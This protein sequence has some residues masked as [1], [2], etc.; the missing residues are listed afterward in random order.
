MPAAAPATLIEA[1][2]SALVAF[3]RQVHTERMLDVPILNH[4]LS[5][6]AVGFALATGQTTEGGVATDAAD[7][8][9]P[10]MIDGIVLTPWFMSLY[11]LP[12]QRQPKT[13]G[14]GAKHMRCFGSECFEFIAGFDDTLGAY[15]SCAMFSPMDG[16]T[17]QM[18]AVATAEALLQ[19]LRVE[20]VNRQAAAPVPAPAVMPGRR[21]FLFGRARA[22]A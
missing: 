3:Y 4:A 21:S 2:V 11:R 1:R 12:L 7:D 19:Q 20:P 22:S 6:A 15:E 8:A 9:A 14:I 13:G 5:V 16:F 17:D 18:Q 10:A